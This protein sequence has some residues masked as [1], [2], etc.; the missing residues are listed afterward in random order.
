M[1]RG[2]SFL[3]RTDG[4]DEALR[5]LA[6]RGANI[7]A[8]LGAY[9]SQY[10]TISLAWADLVAST[11]LLFRLG[12]P[13]DSQ[14]RRAENAEIARGRF[15]ALK[16]NSV[17]WETIIEGNTSIEFEREFD[18]LAQQIIAEN[19]RLLAQVVAR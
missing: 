13:D 12:N 17:D 8:R 3:N 11:E 5:M 1:A 6:L 9:L 14:D 10:P 18:R 2:R 19:S 15:A 7:Q 4:Y 16:L